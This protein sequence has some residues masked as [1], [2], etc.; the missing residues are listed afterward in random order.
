MPIGTTLKVVQTRFFFE[1]TVGKSRI[2][3]RTTLDFEWQLISLSTQ[4]W[5]NMTSLKFRVVLC[6]IRPFPKLISKIKWPG[7]ELPLR[8]K[9]DMTGYFSKHFDWKFFQNIE[10]RLETWFVV[11]KQSFKIGNMNGFM[12]NENL[13]IFS[14]YFYNLLIMFPIDF[15]VSNQHRFQL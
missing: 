13:D 15:H 7:S 8:P 10:M 1:I 9:I 12:A 2:R 11:S 6:R 14:K 5:L 3:R 4:N